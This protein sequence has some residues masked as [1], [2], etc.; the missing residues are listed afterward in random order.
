[1]LN[2]LPLNWLNILNRIFCGWSSRRLSTLWS[3]I[4]SLRPEDR[5]SRWDWSSSYI[6]QFE[7]VQLKFLGNL[8]PQTNS[9]VQY[10]LNLHV[11][12]YIHKDY[13][14]HKNNLHFSNSK[15]KLSATKLSVPHRKENIYP[16]VFSQW[17]RVFIARKGFWRVMGG[18]RRENE[19]NLENSETE[20]QSALQHWEWIYIRIAWTTQYRWGRQGMD[21]ETDRSQWNA[22]SYLLC[23]LNLPWFFGL[24][25]SVYWVVN[26]QNTGAVTYNL[27]F[28]KA[29]A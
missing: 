23:R 19:I 11:I 20:Q 17:R 7:E 10:I 6:S 18:E 22:A 8:S 4:S 13:M 27:Q 29:R 26:C 15:S 1:M 16:P 24:K 28:Q 9:V 5:P 14:K 21:H 25:A 12:V 2:E 3:L